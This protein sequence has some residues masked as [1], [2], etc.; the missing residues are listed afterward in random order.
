MQSKTFDSLQLQKRKKEK[1]G[2]KKGKKID[3][4]IANS[5]RGQSVSTRQ[6]EKQDCWSLA[7]LEDH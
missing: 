6:R 5:A 7:F 2:N 4:T 1:K 3:A